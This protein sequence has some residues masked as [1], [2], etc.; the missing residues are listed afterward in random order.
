MVGPLDPGHDRDPQVFTGGPGTPI[1]DGNKRSALFTAN[2]VLIS[3]GADRLRTVPVDDHDP[4]VAAEFNDLLARAYVLG[5][6]AGVK[7]MLRERGLV[8]IERQG[9][10][11]RVLTEQFRQFP[12]LRS[13]KLGG[14]SSTEAQS[15][16]EN[17][18]RRQL[19]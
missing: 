8:P 14:P 10:D 16:L 13:V 9:E 7:T 11:E 5:E 6:D 12:E 3:S 19:D 2:A 15:P 18:G 4:S 17:D 1:E